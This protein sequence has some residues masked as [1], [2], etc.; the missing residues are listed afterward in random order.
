[1]PVG[2]SNILKEYIAVKSHTEKQIAAAEEIMHLVE[3]FLE[4]EFE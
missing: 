2:I 4:E 1:M 3:A